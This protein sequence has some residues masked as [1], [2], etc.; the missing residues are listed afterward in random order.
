MAKQ[1]TAE[2]VAVQARALR[3]VVA[4]LIDEED[5]AEK[6]AAYRALAAELRCVAEDLETLARVEESLF[7]LE[8]GCSAEAA[9]QNLRALAALGVRP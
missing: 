6:T 7:E 3:K 2:M 4:T 9:A 8:R 5:P 1:T